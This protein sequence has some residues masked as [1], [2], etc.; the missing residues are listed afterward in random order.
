[1]TSLLMESIPLSCIFIKFHIGL[2]IIIKKPLNSKIIK[3]SGLVPETFQRL[4]LRYSINTK[5]L[6]S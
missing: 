3:H 5:Y 4:P 6:F 1:M 2:M